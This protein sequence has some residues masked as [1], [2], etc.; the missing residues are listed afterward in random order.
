MTNKTQVQ[1][2]KISFFLSL[3]VITYATVDTYLFTYHE[4]NTMKVTTPVILG[5]VV[6]ILLCGLLHR[7]FYVWLTNNQIQLSFGRQLSSLPESNDDAGSVCV[8]NTQPEQKHSLT[9]SFSSPHQLKQTS[10]DSAYRKGSF[11]NNYDAIQEDIRKKE[12][13]RQIEIMRAI[14]EYVTLKT[15]P[16]LSKEALATLI[17]N[18]EYMACNQPEFYKPLRSNINNP[19]KSPGLRHLAWNVGERLGV[20]LKKRAAFIKASFPQE[21]ENATHE[22]LKLNLRDNIPSQIPIDPPDKGD[23]R[24]HLDTDNNDSQ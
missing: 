15:V 21:L 13:E 7:F 20:S 10:L 12:A 1:T 8:D 4:I 5:L 14:R 16:Y 17:R 6:A 18:I 23:Y 9:R 22:Y 3:S 19:L 11:L 2:K 24:F